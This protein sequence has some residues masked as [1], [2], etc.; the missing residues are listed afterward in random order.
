MFLEVNVSVVGLLSIQRLVRAHNEWMS[1][2][3]LGITVD[4]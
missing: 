1:E 2:K 4:P 3:L